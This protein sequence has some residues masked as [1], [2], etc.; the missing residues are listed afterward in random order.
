MLANRVCN[1]FLSAECSTTTQL[2]ELRGGGEVTVKK[3]PKPEEPLA[4]ESGQVDILLVCHLPAPSQLL[5]EVVRT[6]MMDPHGW[7][8]LQNMT[9]AFLYP[10]PQSPSD[11]APPPPWVSASCSKLAP[12]FSLPLPRHLA[13]LPSNVAGVSDWL[14]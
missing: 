2:R 11:I 14:V 1:L 5:D 4:P 12:F 3:G 9:S 7:F 13:Q 6:Q 8:L 10:P